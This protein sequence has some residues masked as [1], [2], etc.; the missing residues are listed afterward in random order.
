VSRFQVELSPDAQNDLADIWLSA[1]DRPAVNA[2]ER[3]I[4]QSLGN[5]PTGEGKEVAEGLYRIVVEPLVAYFE[6]D[7]IQNQVMITKFMALP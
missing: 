7:T 2:A 4:F 3:I 6:I 1:A 5:D